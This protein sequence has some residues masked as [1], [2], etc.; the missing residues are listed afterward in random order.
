MHE[1]EPNGVQLSGRD[2]LGSGECG[3][4][5]TEVR[6]VAYDAG[7]TA[8]SGGPQRRRECVQS[9]SVIVGVLCCESMTLP[10]LSRSVAVASICAD[11]PRS[12]PSS[13]E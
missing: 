7:R 2:P 12:A 10:S 9:W 8:E 6:E 11:P 13:N 3:F 4:D 1:R 5:E